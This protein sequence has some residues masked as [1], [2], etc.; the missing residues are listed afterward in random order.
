MALV[1]LARV[2][3]LGALGALGALGTVRAPR[4]GSVN[5]GAQ[6]DTSTP[7]VQFEPLRWGNKKAQCAESRRRAL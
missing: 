3:S 5:G 6:R 4:T 1:R 2:G 7:H